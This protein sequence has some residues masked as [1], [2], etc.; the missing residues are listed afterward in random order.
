MAGK[1]KTYLDS[2]DD[3]IEIINWCKSIGTVT[4]KY[5]NTFN[6]LDFVYGPNLTKDEFKPGMILWNTPIYFDLFLIRSCPIKLIQERLK[7]Q[8]NEEFIQS[9][10]ENRSKYDIFKRNGLGKNLKITILKK[11]DY[12]GN[13]KKTWWWISIGNSDWWYNECNNEW[14]H[15]L[16]GK[17]YNTNVCTKYRGKLTMRKIIRILRKW[18]L[19]SGLEIRII[20]SYDGQKYILKTK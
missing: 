9:V 18:D 11:P 15:R 13:Y 16:E 4:D 1:D 3:Y 8:Y 2:Y 14:V 7:E 20:G 19:P 5:G 10:K 12:K 17:D 6:P